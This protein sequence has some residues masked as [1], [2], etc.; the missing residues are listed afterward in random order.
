MSLLSLVISLFCWAFGLLPI[1]ISGI[2]NTGTLVLTF[3]G[4]L[5]TIIYLIQRKIL[6]KNSFLGRLIEKMYSVIIFGFLAFTLVYISIL[7]GFARFNPPKASQQPSTVIVLGC[8]LIGNRPSTMLARRLTTAADYLESNPQAVCIVSGGQ[9]S[10]EEYSEAEVMKKYL[11]ESGISPE[12]IYTEDRSANTRENLLFS[13]RLA[14]KE[15]LPKSVVISTDGFHQLRAYIYADRY[16]FSP[17]SAISGF[18]PV[19]MLP[20][21]VVREFFAIIQALFL[22]S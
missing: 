21:Y 22:Q 5:F 20:C 4:A 9:G 10:N 11:I 3:L 17:I 19:G 6:L 1:L 13:S 12:R 16:G 8:Q 14:E 18:T 7:I 15:K 2:L